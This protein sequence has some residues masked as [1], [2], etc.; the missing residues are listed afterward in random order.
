[1]SSQ[2]KDAL[3]HAPIAVDDVALARAYERFRAEEVDRLRM[4][5][6]RSTVR[7]RGYEMRVEDAEDV[8][9]AV[10]LEVVLAARAG[11]ISA[12]GNETAIEAA[13]RRMRMPVRRRVIDAYRARRA[14]EQVEVLS[15]V[16]A[17]VVPRVAAPD[18]AFVDAVETLRSI[19]ADRAALLYE[20]IVVGTQDA[21][22]ASRESITPAAIRQRRRR[23]LADVHARLHLDGSET[24]G[25]EAA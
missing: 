21:E 5:A 1:M 16:P 17:E 7:L 6:R 13:H 11:K 2:L 8:L 12:R 25:E 10:A 22:L 4:S 9:G 23:I 24:A 20:S 19:P 3:A 18:L 15:N 14:R